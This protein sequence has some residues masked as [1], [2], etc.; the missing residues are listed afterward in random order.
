[1]MIVTKS[2][3]MVVMTTTLLSLINSLKKEEVRKRN[4]P[5]ILQISVP[6]ISTEIEGALT[7]V[8]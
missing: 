8:S 5:M 2:C 1:M 7:F 6:Q 4:M 3:M